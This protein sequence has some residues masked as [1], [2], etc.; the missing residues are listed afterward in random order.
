MRAAIRAVRDL[1]AERVVAAVAV[2]SLPACTL[3]HAEANELV[4]DVNPAFLRSVG[5]WY[6]DFSP[7]TDGEVRSLLAR[8]AAIAA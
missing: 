8:A 3:L 4:C 1:G 5:E 7:I 6:R 2:A